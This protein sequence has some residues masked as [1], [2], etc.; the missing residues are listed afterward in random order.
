MQETDSGSLV[1]TTSSHSSA[2]ESHRDHKRHDP[3]SKRR[4]SAPRATRRLNL[5]LT[6][7]LY[8]EIERLAEHEGKSMVDIL[9]HGLGLVHWISEEK[10][11]GSQLAII[12]AQ[13]NLHR[14][15]LPL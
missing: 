4:R 12:D 8:H 10:K 9:R 7:T 14:V 1:A 11:K 15:V 3:K 6:E 2:T 13:G 5:A